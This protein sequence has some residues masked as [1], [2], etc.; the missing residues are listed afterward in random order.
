MGQIRLV[1]FWK[2]VLSITVL[3]LVCI[4]KKRAIHVRTDPIER[5]VHRNA[6]ERKTENF[7]RKWFAENALPFCHAE[8]ND[9]ATIFAI[10]CFLLSLYH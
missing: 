2:A 6:K 1:G 8:Y 4:L 7:G 3:N 5:H 9:E 10:F